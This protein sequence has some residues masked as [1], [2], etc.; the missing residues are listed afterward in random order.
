MADTTASFAGKSL[1]YKLDCSEAYHCARMVNPLSVKLLVL[2]SASKTMAYRRLARRLNRAVTESSAFVRNYLEPRLS[3]NI[4]SQYKDDIGCGV[5]FPEQFLPSLRQLFQCL[6]KSK[7]KLSPEKCVFGSEQLSFLGK[8]ITKEG[9]KPENEIIEKYPQTLEKP[10]SVKP[11]NGLF[12]FLQFS[13]SL[14]RNLYEH[15]IPFY[16][17]LRKK[18]FI[19]NYGRN[20]EIFRIPR[21]KTTNENNPNF[22]T[23]KN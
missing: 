17:L 11:V 6:G 10:K 5:Y 4:C 15:M 3:A 20:T 19:W 13:R 18:C 8:F 12:G 22:S 2:N 9:L 7:L 1:F 21:R 16:K 23:S 14:F